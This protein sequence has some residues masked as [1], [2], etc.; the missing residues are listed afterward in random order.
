MP[1]G[2]STS[3]LTEVAEGVSS[4]GSSIIEVASMDGIGVVFGSVGDVVAIAG[5]FDSI[6]GSDST[7]GGFWLDWLQAA[8]KETSE[9]TIN[10]ITDIL[11]WIFFDFFIGRIIE[12]VERQTR[13]I[14]WRL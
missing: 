8:S 4:S 5:G 12:W 1:Q 10:I 9:K 6:G 13:R 11:Y 2:I 7:V 3:G 14:G